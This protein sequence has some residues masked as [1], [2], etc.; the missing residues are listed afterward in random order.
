MDHVERT[1][2]PDAYSE[3]TRRLVADAITERRGI[4]WTYAMQDAA[5]VLDVLAERGLLLPEGAAVEWSW[6]HRLDGTGCSHDV[7]SEEHARSMVRSG[8]GQARRR[9]VGP[10]SP[11]P[12]EPKEGAGGQSSPA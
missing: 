1:P 6:V 8:G 4:A 7:S 10:W 2:M 5:A 9:I 12:P 11:I 3:D